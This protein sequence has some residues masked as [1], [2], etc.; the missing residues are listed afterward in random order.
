MFEISFGVGERRSHWKIII[1]ISL[2]AK[3]K[4]TFHSIHEKKRRKKSHF[5]GLRKKFRH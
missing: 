5:D 3:K 2:F 1:A 4:K